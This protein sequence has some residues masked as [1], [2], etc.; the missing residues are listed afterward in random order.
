MRASSLDDPQAVAWIVCNCE[1]R[2]QVLDLHRWNAEARKTSR[3]VE[4]RHMLER[5]DVVLLVLGLGVG[6]DIQGEYK[7]T[8]LFHYDNSMNA[9]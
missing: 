1:N 8:A 7:W 5:S 9:R 4:G 6:C 3:S 2:R